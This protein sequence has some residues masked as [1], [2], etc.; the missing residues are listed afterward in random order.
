MAA[1]VRLTSALANF[2]PNVLP[3]VYVEA[4][5]I[6]A[7]RRKLFIASLGKPSTLPEKGGKK[8][9]WNILLKEANFYDDTVADNF[10]VEGDDPEGGS[11]TTAKPEVTLIE[12]GRTYDYSKF[13]QLTA[14]SGTLDE[15]IDEVGHQAGAI[16]DRKAGNA[17]AAATNSTDEGVSFTAEALRKAVAKLKGAAQTEANRLEVDTHPSTPGGQFYCALLTPEQAYDML[18]E[19]APTWVQAK[20]EQFRRALTTPFMD[21]YSSELYGAIVKVT[22]NIP[23]VTGPVPDDEVAEVFGKDALLT[24]AL[25]T[26]VIQPRVIIT[27]PESKTDAPARNRGTIAWWALF[28]A[29]ISEQQRVQEIVTDATGIG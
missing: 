8:V 10:T 20:D 29:V 14:V 12:L 9:R 11:F 6:R 27:P 7:L 19:G 3:D 16:I 1:P 13:M 23:R 15:V 17:L 5:F 22:N 2:G 18:G 4:R 21:D 28:E 26:S 24:A 25:D